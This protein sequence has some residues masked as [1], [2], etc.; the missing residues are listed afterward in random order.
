MEFAIFLVLLV[1]LCVLMASSG[2]S[3]FSNKRD[4]TDPPNDVS[5]MRLFIDYRTGCHYLGNPMGGITPRFDVNGDQICEP[6]A[7]SR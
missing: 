1:I 3:F 5:G 7:G 6:K 4:D 2:Q